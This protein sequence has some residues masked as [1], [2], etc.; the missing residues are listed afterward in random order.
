MGLGVA[1]VTLWSVAGCTAVL[2]DGNLDGPDGVKTGAGGGSVAGGA[3]SGAVAGAGASA[4]SAAGD[5]PGYKPIHRLSSV[6]YNATVADVL[7]TKLQP[8]SGNLYEIGGFDNLAEAQQV[9]SNEYQRFYDAAGALADDAFAR[10][11]FKSQWVTCGT[12]DISCVSGIVQ[13][14]GLH[15]LRRPLTDGEVKNYQGVYQAAQGQGESHE[16]AL[17]QVLRALLASSEFLYRMEFDADPTSPDRHPLSS[18]ELASRLSY[19]LWSSAP[20]DSLLEEAESGKLSEPAQLS[21]VVE[22]M[23]RE[24]KSQRLVANFAGQWLGARQ[25][26]SHA[27]ASTFYRWNARVAQ[28]ASQE[29]LSYFSEFL[30][31]D[32]SWF[33]FPTADFNYIDGEL[34]L[35]YGIPTELMGYGTFERVE[36]TADQRRGFFG[37]VGFLA[38]SSFDRRTSP[39]KRGHWIAGNLLCQEPPPPP[40]D[41]PKLDADGG[42]EQSP[43]LAVRARLEEHRRNPGCAACHALFD[44]YGLALEEYDAIGMYRS[45]YE[46]GTP[47]DGAVTLP[48]SMEQ[49]E[50]TSIRGLDGLSE[51]LAKDPRLGHCL[52][53]KLLSYGLGRVVG[54]SDA[55]Q[56][57]RIEQ[58]WL[59]PN[60]VPSVRRLIQALV[61]SDTFQRRRGGT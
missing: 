18:Y 52:A 55:A 22:R 56:L 61:A 2:G 11:D 12:N 27:A 30:S 32:R 43:P 46:D 8:A 48:P 39:S 15:L 53:Q 23:L 31:D 33:E 50:G 26:P 14:L 60:Q 25:L 24:P 21:E 40:A 38:L 29:M 51:A 58:Q 57:A 47:I 42:A 20:D 37:L 1:I 44:P 5:A 49:P 4:G 45:Q 41:V 28:A 36:Y 7:G 13:K 17:K 35:V 6:E 9:D 19:F 54:A 10:A 59:A 3:G 16:G 34:A